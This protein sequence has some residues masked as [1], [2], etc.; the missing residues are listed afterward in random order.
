MYLE[1]EFQERAIGENGRVEGHFH[2]FRMAVM[3]A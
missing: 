3:F 2:C 1:E